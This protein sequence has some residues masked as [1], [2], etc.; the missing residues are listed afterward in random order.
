MN[1]LPGSLVGTQSLP[2][3]VDQSLLSHPSV[4]G[5]LEGSDKRRQFLEDFNGEHTSSTSVMNLLA[6]ADLRGIENAGMAPQN[7]AY[8]TP[9]SCVYLG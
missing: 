8:Q 4:A 2:R 9:P 3:P 5:L 1:R 6:A 7:L